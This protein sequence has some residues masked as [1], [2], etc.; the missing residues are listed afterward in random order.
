MNCD[1]AARTRGLIDGGFQLDGRVLI[2]G[3]QHSVAHA[4]RTRL[5]DLYEIRTLLVL[6][7]N[8]GNDLISRVGVGCVRQHMLRGIET[9]GILVAAENVDRIAADPQA[10]S[11]NRAAIDGIA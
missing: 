10:R 11:L 4:I 9:I 8:R 5:I 2:W 7:A 3:V 1:V 6:P